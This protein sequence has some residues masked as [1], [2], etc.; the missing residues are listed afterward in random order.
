LLAGRIKL[1]NH[2]TFL[3]PCP[4]VSAKLRNRAISSGR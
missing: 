1:K 4:T 3:H 2:K